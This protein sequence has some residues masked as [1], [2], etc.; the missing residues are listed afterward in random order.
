MRTWP[1]R[2]YRTLCAVRR[3]CTVLTLD[4]ADRSIGSPDFPGSRHE[5]TVS[6][7]LDSLAKALSTAY[8][9]QTELDALLRPLDQRF[10]DL[11]SQ[12]E[13]L[14]TNARQIV[15]AAQ[16]KSWSGELLQAV[17]NDRPNN[18]AVRALAELKPAIIE[19]AVISRQR[20]P[21]DRPSLTCGRAEQWNSVSQ[22]AKRKESSGDRRARLPRTGH[23]SIS[24]I[25]SRRSSPRIR[26]AAW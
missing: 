5:P 16:D 4:G 3:V 14:L 22:C 24:G 13:S 9:N 20:N 12:K 17:L 7:S 11:T 21:G 10:D 8:V 23:R 6:S 19:A 2:E 18:A 26:R 15:F 25:A 1:G